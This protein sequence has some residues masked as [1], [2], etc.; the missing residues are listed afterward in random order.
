MLTDGRFFGLKRQKVTVSTVGVVPRIRQVR[1]F[2]YLAVY[3]NWLAMRIRNDNCVKAACM[4]SQLWDYSGF[5]CHLSAW[6][7]SAEAP[8]PILRKI[9]QPWTRGNIQEQ[10]RPSCQFAYAEPQTGY[11][12]YTLTLQVCHCHL[13]KV[14]LAAHQ[15]QPYV[16]YLREDSCVS[17]RLTRKN[18]IIPG[19]IE[20][21][22]IANLKVGNLC[23]QTWSMTIYAQDLPAAEHL[24]STCMLFSIQR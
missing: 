11:N 7:V 12:A 17:Q 15:T 8:V 1:F 3:T 24:Y 13:T 14:I 19:R 20:M 4:F 5:L 22:V 18:Q 9:T 2:I 21:E 6:L 16:L 23:L 10:N